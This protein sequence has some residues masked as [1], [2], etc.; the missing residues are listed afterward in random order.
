MTASLEQVRQ[1]QKVCPIPM[2]VILDHQ[3]GGNTPTAKSLEGN[4][5]EKGDGRDREADSEMNPVQGAN[6]A[7]KEITPDT[8]EDESFNDM[9]APKSTVEEEGGAESTAD[10]MTI[11]SRDTEMENAD[12][13]GNDDGF[14]APTRKHQASAASV[15]EAA[16]AMEGVVGTNNSYAALMPLSSTRIRGSSPAKSPSGSSPRKKK[17]KVSSK[18]MKQMEEQLNKQRVEEATATDDDIAVSLLGRFGGAVKAG[19]ASVTG[20]ATQDDTVTGENNNWHDNW[21][22][23][24]SLFKA[25]SVALW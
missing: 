6:P 9:N 5:P 15:V 17:P 8:P 22:S 16:N 1:A 20:Y 18:F 10:G 25:T 24:I 2:E 23:S 4:T 21:E 13:E 12:T 19:V 14:C 11:D 3:L 7:L